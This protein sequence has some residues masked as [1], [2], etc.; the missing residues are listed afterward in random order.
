MA[1]LNRV[2]PHKLG[3][4]RFLLRYPKFP[5]DPEFL[6]YTLTLTII[7]QEVHDI[8]KQHLDNFLAF[9]GIVYLPY[10]IHGRDNNPWPP[11]ALWLHAY[12]GSLDRSENQTA[13]EKEAAEDCHGM[14]SAY[15][16]GLSDLKHKEF[17]AK[18]CPFLIEHCKKPTDL[19]LYAAVEN[20]E[21]ESA[22]V[23]R[24][25]EARSK[26][27]VTTKE[28]G[29]KMDDKLQKQ[30]AN[31]AKELVGSMNLEL[32]IVSSSAGKPEAVLNVFHPSNKKRRT[33]EK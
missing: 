6:S 5:E 2:S 4:T 21:L 28:V 30:F 22:L 25:L 10:L 11:H 20:L 13:H 7:I 1:P 9:I 3:K 33:S 26:A 14:L 12:S 18:N 15:R 27:S 23:D 31:K 24:A 32:E 8:D 17:L 29:I 16:G 19:K